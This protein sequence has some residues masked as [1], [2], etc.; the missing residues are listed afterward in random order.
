MSAAL[1]LYR[2]ILRAARQM[3]TRNRRQFILKKARHEF[4]AA[5]AETDPARIAFLMDYG[6]L[7]LDNIN[8]QAAHLK[9]D[10]LFAPTSR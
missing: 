10:A 5:K 9:S 6:A 2:A 1:S 8:A 3:P 4:E 7:S